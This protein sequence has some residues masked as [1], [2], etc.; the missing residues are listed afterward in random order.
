MCEY[1]DTVFMYTRML[2]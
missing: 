2:L 1:I